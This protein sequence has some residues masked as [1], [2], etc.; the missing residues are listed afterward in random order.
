M[1]RKDVTNNRGITDNNDETNRKDLANGME[2]IE[3]EK[4]CIERKKCDE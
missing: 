2:R 1:N 3:Q 4:I